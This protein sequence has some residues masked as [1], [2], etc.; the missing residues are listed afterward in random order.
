[1]DQSGLT[2][3]KETSLFTVPSSADPLGRPVDP[4]FD[5]GS[6]VFTITTASDLPPVT[7]ADTTIDATTQTTNVGDTNALTLGAGGTVGVDGLALSQVAGPEVQVRDT[8]ALTHGIR[9]Q[10]ADV[11]VRGLAVYGFGGAQGEG[12]IRVDDGISGALIEQNVIGSTA[13]SFAD[14]G[15]ALRNFEGVY[16]GGGDN[17]TI[18]NNLIGF[19]SI[20]GVFLENTSTG[21]T[22]EGNEIRDNGLGDATGDGIALVSATGDF[23]GNLVVGSSSQGI[24]ITSSA[25]NTFTNNTLTGNGVG[26]AS[27]VSQTNAVALRSSA[28]PT[29]FDRNVVQT[30]YGA[31]IAVNDGAT[32]I[33]MTHNSFSDN[34][35]IIARNGDPPTGQIGIDLNAPGD[36]N[37]LGL[38]DQRLGRPARRRQRPAELPGTGQRLDQRS[39]PRARGLVPARHGDRAVRRRPGPDGLRRGA[40]LEDHVDR[41][42]HRWGRGRPPR[43]SRRHVERLRS[44]SDQRYRAGRGHDQPVPIRLSHTVRRDGRHRVDGDRHGRVGKHLRVQRAGDRDLQRHL[45]HRLR[46][47]QLRRR[48]GPRLGDGERRRAQLRGRTRRRHRR[49]LRQ[50]RCLRHQHNHGRWRR[51]GAYGFA[52]A[53]G[54]FTVRVVNDTVTSSRPG[55]DGS[56]LAVQTYR[57]DGAAEGAGDGAKKVG[58]ERPSNEDA[59][60]NSGAQTLAALQGTDLDTDGVTEWTQSIVTVDTSGGDVSG[61]DFGFNFDTIVNTND[62]GQGTLRQFILNSNLLQ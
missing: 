52:V 22:V 3:G 40:N 13:A 51:R 6:G 9:I 57:A 46:G 8:G 26:T 5:G 23:T 62:A 43:R 61:V 42:G 32:G 59:A 36:D 24:V 34:G 11:T 30:N 27:T 25:N 18:R 19:G 38:Y 20:R 48:N 39:Q 21:W 60:A 37:N 53:P 4:G 33:R 2:A 15:A 16:S 58:G 56:E 41:G 7:G 50:R 17:G 47:R 55:S 29:T 49:A 10:A 54:T 31:G 12:G 28:G 44:G 14:P 45:R 35:T 1:L